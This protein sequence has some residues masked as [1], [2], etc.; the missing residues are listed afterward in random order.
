[1]IT[2]SE[3]LLDVAILHMVEY[4]KIAPEGAGASPLAAIYSGKLNHLK[5][6][7]VCFVVSGGNIDVSMLGRVLQRGLAV[8]GRYIKFSVWVVDRPGGISD[9]T[10]Y[11]TENGATIKD[12]YCER[13]WLKDDNYNV[14]VTVMCEVKDIDAAVELKSAIESKYEKTDFTDFPC[15][16]MAKQIMN[17]NKEAAGDKA[18]IRDSIRGSVKR[19]NDS[20]CRS[21]RNK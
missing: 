19:C 3:D 14:K 12:L 4:E 7:K 10:A 9:M 13:A 21:N 5:G 1:M 2:V 6:K 11:I 8:L 17:F 20:R 18:S 15:I 16:N